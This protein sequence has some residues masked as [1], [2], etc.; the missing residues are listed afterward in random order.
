MWLRVDKF[1][2]GHKKKNPYMEK[3][4]SDNV[5]R[6]EENAVNQH[7]L[8]FSQCFLIFVRQLKCNVIL[9]TFE[10]SSSNPFDFGSFDNVVIR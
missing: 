8:L 4:A 10:L 1:Q 3:K 6:K 9:D 2:H 5:V 7:F